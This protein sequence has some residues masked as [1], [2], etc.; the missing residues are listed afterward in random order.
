M[1]I[2]I[3]GV[4][5]LGGVIASRVLAAGIDLWMAT[6]TPESAAALKRDG[7][8]VTGVGPA[9]FLRPNHVTAFR[10]LASHARFHLIILATKAHEAVA[11]APAAIELL[12]EG[13]TLL[14]IQNGGVADILAARFGTNR[15]LGGLSNLGATMVSTGVYEQRNA[16][17]LLIGELAGGESRRVDN[18]RDTLARGVDTRSTSN[19]RGAVWSK[20]LLNCSVTTIGAIAGTTMREYIR[21]PVGRRVFDRTYEE[22]L[23]V[24]LAAGARPEPMFVD[25]VPPV[26]ALPADAD[27]RYV[28][29]TRSIVE[30]YGDV[31]PSMLQDFERQRRTEVEFINGY[32]A[33]L[34][35]RLGVAAPFNDALVRVVS[36]ISRGEASPDAMLLDR[37]EQIALA[38]V[39]AGAVSA[40]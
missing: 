11:A 39:R 22:A 37:V 21:L 38:A 7:L 24:A 32:V 10:A 29:W 6:R 36:G 30:A 20:L 5:A 28:A 4:G 33:E 26:D 35:Q 40:H 23:R 2:L 9:V 14:P 27:G 3:V 15:V 13:G 18:I 1:E 8:Q 31:K 17:Y 34:S 12:R 19:I 25:P 16:G